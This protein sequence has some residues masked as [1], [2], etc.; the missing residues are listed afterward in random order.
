MRNR[1][2]C[3]G[4]K[5]WRFQTFFNSHATKWSYRTNYPLICMFDILNDFPQGKCF[6]R[7]HLKFNSAHF[8]D[9]R[10][11]R[12]L[13]FENELHR[14]WK[15]EIGIQSDIPRFLAIYNRSPFC[16][17][18]IT[19]LY[20]KINTLGLGINFFVA[21]QLRGLNPRDQRFRHLWS[22]L[23]RKWSTSGSLGPKRIWRKV[24]KFIFMTMSDVDATVKR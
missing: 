20:R 15:P 11:N 21:W 16:R 23:L 13:I 8:G 17:C 1:P 7:L 5:L 3:Y 22:Q 10:S 4:T 24:G 19:C 18:R 12:K 9:I 2:W 14:K 6:Q